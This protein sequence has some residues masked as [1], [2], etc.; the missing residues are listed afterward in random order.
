LGFTLDTLD[1]RQLSLLERYID[2]LEAYN[3]AYSLVS[4]CTREEA[5]TRHILDS[6]APLPA[7]KERLQGKRSLADA[8]SGAGLPGIPLA[9]ACPEIQVTLIERMAKR[10]SFLRIAVQDLGLSN[11]NIEEKNIGERRSGPLFDAVAFRALSSLDRKLVKTL[12][13]LLKKDGF[14]AAWKGRLEKTAQE[15]ASLGDTVKE[16]EIIPVTVPFMEAE[17]C[18]LILR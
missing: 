15:A 8:G 1:D 16:S 6:L 12:K 18:L 14:L 13:T 17:R 2:L 5:A 9:I 10:V 3:P 4:D 7:L 11:V